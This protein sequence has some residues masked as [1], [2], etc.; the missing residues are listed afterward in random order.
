[1]VANRKTRVLVTQQGEILHICFTNWQWIMVASYPGLLTPAFVACSTNTGEGLV[2]LSHV[3]WCTWMCGGVAH[4]FCTAVKRL[5][6]SKKRHHARL[7]D[8]ECSVVVHCTWLSFTRPSPALVLQATNT[9][10][11]RAG[12]EASAMVVMIMLVQSERS[13]TFPGVLKQNNCVLL[14]YQ[15]CD[16]CLSSVQHLTISL[17]A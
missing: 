11:R 16:Q 9:G 1:M 4:S 6:E 12:Y 3:R 5:S 13:S 10:V 17:P 14:P 7:S 2:K 15:V 8:I